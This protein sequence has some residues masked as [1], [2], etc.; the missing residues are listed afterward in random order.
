[1]HQRGVES[2]QRSHELLPVRTQPAASGDHLVED[3]TGA[4]MQHAALA[5]RET[6]AGAG[7]TLFRFRCFCFSQGVGLGSTET[8][9]CA[10]RAASPYVPEC[11]RMGRSGQVVVPPLRAHL[12]GKFHDCVPLGEQHDMNSR[13][14]NG[15][16]TYPGCR[17]PG[18]CEPGSSDA[19]R[20]AAA[21]PC[22]ARRRRIPLQRPW[23]AA[24]R[25]GR[26]KRWSDENRSDR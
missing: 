7:L 10:A 14:R 22:T 3:G 20:K 1:M 24:G 19:G 5:G 11:D 2:A 6:L 23:D 13:R 8:P 26:C 25:G 21:M 9:G 18:G 15:P 4:V 12:P 16:T 17:T